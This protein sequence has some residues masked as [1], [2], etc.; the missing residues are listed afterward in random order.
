MTDKNVALLV[1]AFLDG[2]EA[3]AIRAVRPAEL[4]RGATLV[5]ESCFD[6][7]ADPRQIDGEMARQLIADLLPR[8]FGTGDA[9]VPHM[10]AITSAFFAHLARTDMVT[11]AFEID[12]AL[13]SFDAEG[14][15]LAVKG[16]A[17]G[18]RVGGRVDTIRSRGDKVG[19]NDPCPCG[20]GRKFK[21]CCARLG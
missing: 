15:A 13:A 4:R 12:L 16:I 19:R 3:R 20:S 18:G 17:D 8:K 1:A 10:P 7:G 6:L 9:L 21:Q 5:V 2:S 14:F 11:H